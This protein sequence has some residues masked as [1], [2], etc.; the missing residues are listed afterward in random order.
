MGRR[1]GRDLSELP[2]PL[3]VRQT[4]Q[5]LE[6]LLGEEGED[7]RGGQQE[8]QQ[9]P[10]RVHDVLGRLDTFSVPFSSSSSC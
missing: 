6:R 4:A 3:Q 2:M 9:H 8:E 10:S 5:I 1:R 7:G